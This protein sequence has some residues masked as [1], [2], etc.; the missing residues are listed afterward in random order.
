MVHGFVR[1]SMAGITGA[2]VIDSISKTMDGKINT[3]VSELSAALNSKIAT[4]IGAPQGTI[5]RSS[6]VS[7]NYLPDASTNL[8]TTNI[9]PGDSMRM[10]ESSGK[11]V[12]DFITASSQSAA[13]MERSYQ[14]LVNEEKVQ[15]IHEA[16]V[17]KTFGTSAKVPDPRPASD[18]MYHGYVHNQT[19]PSRI[20]LI[21]N[22]ISK[23]NSKYLG[24]T[25]FDTSWFKIEEDEFTVD[26]E[27]NVTIS[28]DDDVA[29]T[30]IIFR[31]DDKFDFSA[32]AVKFVDLN[33]TATTPAEQK[34]EIENKM[35]PDIS[36]LDLRD[37]DT[38]YK[39]QS[40]NL[41]KVE[42]K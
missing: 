31:L 10:V 12:S 16:L 6:D 15:E 32:K 35:G 1:K 24:I 33:P 25:L 28:F 20:W 8:D 4:A 21:P 30:A 36:K 2:S 29:G 34:K 42:I 9:N 27:Y 40:D 22:K 11:T 37:R 14:E 13:G 19:S 41:S 23:L 18:T 38:M 7:P 26:D 5:S 39:I 3:S 17:E